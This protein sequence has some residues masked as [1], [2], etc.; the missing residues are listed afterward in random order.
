MQKPFLEV[1]N[2][3]NGAPLNY[4]INENR[5]LELLMVVIQSELSKRILNIKKRIY[6]NIEYGAQLIDC[7]YFNTKEDIKTLG[8]ELKQ[9]LCPFDFRI[10]ENIETGKT[11]EK[12]VLYRTYEELKK[13]SHKKIA[14]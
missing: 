12:P 4:V 9:I 5:D 11:S 6:G 3:E 7:L 1:A 8:E 10:F 14:K 13:R 2:Y